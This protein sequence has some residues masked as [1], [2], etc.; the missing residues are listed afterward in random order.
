MNILLWK[1]QCKSSFPS[2]VYHPCY[3]HPGGTW[4]SDISN[5]LLSVYYWLCLFIIINMSDAMEV[6][7]GKYIIHHIGIA[8]F[9]ILWRKWCFMAATRSFLYLNMHHNAGGNSNT[10]I[11]KR[12]TTTNGWQYSIN[13]SPIFADSGKKRIKAGTHTMPVQYHETIIEPE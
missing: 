13:T 11:G 12:K 1:E 10:I 3:S 4:I 5:S 2:S 6:K 7:K 9:H 8:L